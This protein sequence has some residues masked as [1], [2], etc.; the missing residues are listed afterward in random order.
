[1]RFLKTEEQ[2]NKIYY[3]LNLCSYV[4]KNLEVKKSIRMVVVLCTLYSVLCTLYSVLCQLYSVLSP[5]L[6]QNY[7]H[8]SIPANRRHL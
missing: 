8:L 1:M 2:K 3:F 4:K 7:I 5:F 6:L